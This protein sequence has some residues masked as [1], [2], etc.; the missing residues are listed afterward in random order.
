MVC[1]N[2]TT[3][4]NVFTRSNIATDIEIDACSD[5]CMKDWVID[6]KE[7]LPSCTI[8][9]NFIDATQHCQISCSTRMYN[10]TDRHCISDAA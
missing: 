2:N 10:I 3:V 9:T 8:E 5:V 1:Y 6:G 4:C 7:C